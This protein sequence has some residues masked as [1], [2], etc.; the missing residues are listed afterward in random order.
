MMLEAVVTLPIEQAAIN[1]AAAVALSSVIGFERQ[2]HNRL[3]GLRTNTLVALGAATFVVFSDIVPG[4]GSPTRIA[5]QVVSGIGFL[6]AGLIF[7]EGLS[8][9]GLNTAATLWCSAAVGV[10]AGAGYLA[11]AAV[12]TSFVAFINLLLR[13][14]VRVINRQPLSTNE[15]E[16]GY[17]ICVTCRSADEAHIRALLQG[18]AAGDLSLRRLDSTDV[19][20]TGQ[21]IVNAH[22]IA[23][24][25]VDA[26]IEN[27]VGRL[28]L[29]QT[30][31][32]ARW[33][34]QTS[35]DLDHQ[36][37][38][39]SGAAGLV[40]TVVKYFNARAGATMEHARAG[41]VE[42]PTQQTD[43]ILLAHRTEPSRIFDRN[44]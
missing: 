37:L 6:G 29:E 25:R 38:T 36:S 2:W 4:E 8:V 14:I 13:P 18:F 35:L 9:R 10:L 44:L 1:L 12:A 28:S 33:Q 15:L 39:V 3:A 26:V 42:Q 19:N 40:P 7:R 41:I 27:I 24:S 16:V 5:A 21:V 11:A 31:C 22:L 43:K 23:H 34:V 20:D 30:I 32:A 17:L